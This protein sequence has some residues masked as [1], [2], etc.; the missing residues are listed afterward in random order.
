MGKVKQLDLLAEK[1]THEAL[2]EI[3]KICE[4]TL[5]G[6]LA[7]ELLES[8]PNSYNDAHSYLMKLV[9]GKL[10]NKIK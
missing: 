3:Y 2:R 9:I 10:A 4:W 1:A 5:S 6:D 8:A 7:D